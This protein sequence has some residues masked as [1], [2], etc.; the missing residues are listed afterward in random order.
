MTLSCQAED[1]RI[2]AR[3]SQWP[4]AVTL[5]VATP[6]MGLHTSHARQVL[7]ATIPLADAIFNLQ[8]ALLLVDAL[9]ST[10]YEDLRDLR[11]AMKDRWHQPARA[12]LVP[13]LTQA[14]AFDDPEILGVC[15]SGAGP[16]LV[17]LA[18]DGGTRATVLL[19][20][21]YKGLGL[22]CTIRVLLAQPTTDTRP[23]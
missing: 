4:D 10:R 17:A 20:E 16:S 1:G 13:G 12:A 7:P 2:L 3:A 22:P 21:L 11:E 23:N 6:E 19:T 15:L 9:R 14:I 5:V 8:R 18:S